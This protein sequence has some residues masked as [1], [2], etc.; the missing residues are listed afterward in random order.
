M[1]VI[2]VPNI[3]DPVLCYAQSMLMERCT[4]PKGHDKHGSDRRH[5]WEGLPGYAGRPITD[6]N[7]EPERKKK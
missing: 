2:Q 3:V 5:T 6:L 4:K 7:P 1:K